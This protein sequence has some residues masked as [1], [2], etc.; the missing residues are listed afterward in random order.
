M[1]DQVEQFIAKLTEWMGSPQFYSQLGIIILVLILAFSLSTL[2]KRHSPILKQPPQEGALQFLRNGVYQIRDLLFPLFIIMFMA[3]AIDVSEFLIKESW[4]VRIAEGLAVVLMIYSLISRF[5]INHLLK[6]LI[7]WIAIP[8]A[9]LQVFGL[10]DNVVVYLES[11]FV[12]VGNIK[13]SAYGVVRVFLFGAILFWL[14]RV[15]NRIGQRLIREQAGLDVRA[16]EL[17]AKLYQ[18]A[19]FVVIAIILLQVMGVN[20]TA[21]AVF[22]GALGVGLG[23][24]L[25]SIASNFISGVIL[26]LDRSLAVGDYIELADGRKGT[27]RELNM[28]STLLETYDGK[29]IMVPNEQFITTSFVNW[30]HKNYKQR[31]SIELQVAY[32]TDLHKLFKILREVVSSHPKVLSGPDLPIEEVADAEILGF[33]ESGVNILIEFWMEGIDDGPNR[34]GADLLLMIW[35]AL[36]ENQIEIPFPQREVKIVKVGEG[37]TL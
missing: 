8:I 18:V 11:L 27:I 2:L 36:K 15:I 16:R 23:F 31:Y 28:R 30:T 9:I 20:I 32:S 10:L 17:V 34:V 13:I 1:R 12:E 19:L 21:L 4:L 5:V 6:I 29:D 22:G 24:G 14:G 3:I 26:L 25:Q 33:G 35:D 37:A 7:K